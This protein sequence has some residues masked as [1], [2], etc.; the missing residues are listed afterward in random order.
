MKVITS[1]IPEEYVKDLEEFQEEENVNRAEAVRRLLTK[2]ITEWK[3]ERALIL[4]R[5]HK[6]TL[7]RA[8]AMADVTYVEMLELASEIDVGLDLEELEV[9]D[10]AI[11]QNELSFK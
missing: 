11:T 6:I 9:P 10:E 2:A 3:K 5:D 7:R 1:R 8:A 4:L